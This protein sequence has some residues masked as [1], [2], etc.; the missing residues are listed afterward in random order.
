MDLQTQDVL[1]QDLEAL[2]DELLLPNPDEPK[3][4]LLMKAVK[5]PYSTDTVER[6]SVVLDTMNTL[7]FNQKARKALDDLR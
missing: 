2:V 6:I 4:E 7:L 5:I 3:V 1:I